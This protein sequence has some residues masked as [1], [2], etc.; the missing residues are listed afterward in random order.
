ME[1]EVRFYYSSDSKD[2]KFKS[3]MSEVYKKQVNDLELLVSNFKVASAIIHYDETSPHL[4]I[5]GVPIK[6]KNKNGME[7]QVG[8]SDVF[9]KESLI[10]LQDKMRTLCIE[11]FN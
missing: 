9:T 2:N 5:V 3:K 7:K 8:K 4:H 1:T 11:E 10:R 6:Y